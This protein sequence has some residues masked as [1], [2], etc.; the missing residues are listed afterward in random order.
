MNVVPSFGK[1]NRSMFVGLF[2]GE[3]SF[4]QSSNT[5]KTL[6]KSIA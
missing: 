1:K 5:I 2:E 4:V 3:T 6:R